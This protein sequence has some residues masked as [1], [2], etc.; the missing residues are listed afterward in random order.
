[1]VAELS[2]RFIWEQQRAL[3][4]VG[5]V[6]RSPICL[7]SIAMASRNWLTTDKHKQCRI[8]KIYF[9]YCQ[10]GQDGLPTMAHWIS[11][12]ERRQRTMNALG[13]MPMRVREH[14]KNITFYTYF[15]LSSATYDTTA[16]KGDYVY[17][18]D[19]PLRSLMWAGAQIYMS[20]VIV[21]VIFFLPS[22]L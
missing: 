7:F 9:K 6:S 1:M 16:A 14:N 4:F 13:R 22:P 20:F 15:I 18:F 12:R 19:I 2:G 5:V 3:G 11:G 21:V 8:I 17:E 10:K